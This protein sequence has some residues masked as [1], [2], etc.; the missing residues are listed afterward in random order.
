MENVILVLLG[1]F[2]AI[3]LVIGAKVYAHA[4]KD[5]KVVVS[6]SLLESFMEVNRLYSSQVSEEE[7]QQKLPLALKKMEMQM[8][9]HN[10]EFK[11]AEKLSAEKVLG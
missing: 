8:E 4:C 5:H 6:A 3:I 1:F 7:R 9:L 11:Y 2:I 10:K